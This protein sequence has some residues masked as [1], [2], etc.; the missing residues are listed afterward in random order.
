MRPG[1]A[2]LLV[3]TDA[4]RSLTVSVDE[5]ALLLGISRGLAYRLVDAGVIPSVRLGRRIVV[6]RKQLDQ[7]LDQPERAG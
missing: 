4:D 1:A 7:M 3:V 5:A 6:P 2:H